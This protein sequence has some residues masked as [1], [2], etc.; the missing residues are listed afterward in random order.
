M[1]TVKYDRNTTRYF[2]IVDYN[3][4]V[5]EYIEVRFFKIPRCRNY[6]VQH[7]L[8]KIGMQPSARRAEEE[9]VTWCAKKVPVLRG[10]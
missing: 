1:G 3:P 8:Y 4:N 2:R 5:V 6:L 7:T 9:R 10:G